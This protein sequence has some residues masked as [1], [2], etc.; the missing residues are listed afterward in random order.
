MQG[1]KAEPKS[2][3]WAALVEILGKNETELGGILTQHGKKVA[4]HLGYD[5]NA[6]KDTVAMPVS[7]SQSVCPIN[8]P[9]VLTQPS[10]AFQSLLLACTASAAMKRKK[11]TDTE[12]ELLIPLAVSQ[13]KWSGQAQLHTEMKA[14]RR[15]DKVHRHTAMVYYS[16]HA[17]LF[18]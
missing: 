13:R 8:S 17:K 18:R 3:N 10:T 14:A 6:Q 7:S 15:D 2:F 5:V 9:M 12:E 4:C 16:N 1:I 11:K